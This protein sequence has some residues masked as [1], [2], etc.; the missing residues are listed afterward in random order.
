MKPPLSQL[1]LSNLLSLRVPALCRNILQIRNETGKYYFLGF[2]NY[3]Y[4]NV[5]RGGVQTPHQKFNPKRAPLLL[6]R[7]IIA[8]IISY[9]NPLVFLLW[10]THVLP[11]TGLW[12]KTT[13]SRKQMS[14]KTGN[15]LVANENSEME[16]RLQLQRSLT[17]V[18]T[19][20][21]RDL[22]EPMGPLDIRVAVAHKVRSHS[23]HLSWGKGNRKENTNHASCTHSVTLSDHRVTGIYVQFL[24]CGN[25]IQ[26]PENQ[27]LP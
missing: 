10:G 2:L 21:N 3:G 19:K 8:T 25:W 1:R 17:A 11:A 9:A 4:T 5:T 14:A 20:K 27:D 26:H 18:F 24:P 23:G 15:R 7:V 13:R 16:G 12:G 6:N 22:W